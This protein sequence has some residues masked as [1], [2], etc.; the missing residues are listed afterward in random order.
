M[1]TPSQEYI[2]YLAK[3]ARDV[4]TYQ[5]QIPSE[6]PIYEVNLDTR[7]IS[8]PQTLSVQD[9]H[10]AETIYFIMDRYYDQQDLANT[11][12]IIIF[13][14]AKDEQ[15]IYLIPAYDITTQDGK[16]I[17][18]WN[19]QGAVTKYSGT[20]QFAFKFF[21][22]RANDMDSDGNI[23]YVLNFELNTL[24]SSGKILKGWGSLAS[25]QKTINDITISGTLLEE[26]VKFKTDIEDIRD[27]IQ[28]AEDKFK[29]FWL[30]V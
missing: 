24:I 12:G 26:I 28:Q 3:I 11:V 15:Y 10:E 9:D 30:D 13:K 2:N 23:N 5:I 18:G 1:I 19:I 20:V 14:N 25:A 21:D 27:K 4:P 8:A 17:F 29:I 16:I 6:E 7:V 22:I